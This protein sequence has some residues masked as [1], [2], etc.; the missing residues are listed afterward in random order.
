MPTN[1]QLAKQEADIYAETLFEA[2]NKAGGQDAV[3]EVRAQIEEIIA[4]NRSHVDLTDALKDMSYSPEQRKALVEHVFADCASTLQSMLGV[5]AE[6]G[7]IDMLSRVWNGYNRE[8]AEKLHVVVVDVTTRVALDDHLRKVIT[9][10]VSAD[11]G[12]NIVLR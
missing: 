9:D 5:M 12:S 10:K 1:R 8:I 6:R 11:L 7:D 4:Y 3:L 2:Q